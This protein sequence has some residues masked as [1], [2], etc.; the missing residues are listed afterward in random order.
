MTTIQQQSELTMV[1]RN[2]IKS[3]VELL[4][5]D[6]SLKVMSYIMDGDEVDHSTLNHLINICML[7]RGTSSMFDENSLKLIPSLVWK[8]I[9]KK[10][11]SY[12]TP[13]FC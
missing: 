8:S 3:H 4:A 6:V 2:T 13:C 12:T 9:D 5:S 11:M 10:V 1:T 7:N